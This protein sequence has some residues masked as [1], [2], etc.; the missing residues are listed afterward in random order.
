MKPPPL[1][2]D[3]SAPTGIGVQWL[4][5]DADHEGQR[6]DNYLI[7]RLK[8]APRSLIYRILR[9]GEVR[10]NKGRIKP[11][12]RLHAGDQVRVPPVRL[13]VGT[14]VPKPS[15][16]LQRRLQH[17]VLYEDDDLL[18]VSK[19]SGLAV[20]GGSGIS[21]GLIE[22]LRQ[23]RPDSTLEL[24]HRLDRETSGCLMVAKNRRCLRAVQAQFREGKVNK[25]Y[26]ALAAGRWPNRRREVNTSLLKGRSSSGELIVRAVEPGTN[27]AKLSL[28]KY[29]VLQRYNDSTLLEV[30]PVTGRTHQIR[31]HCQYLGHAIVADAKY[32]NPEINVSFRKFGLKR[33]FLHAAGLQLRDQRGQL[34]EVNAPL[35]DD[36]KLVLDNLASSNAAAQS[37]KI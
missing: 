1:Q 30:K 14:P 13:G 5:I 33:L 28:T 2:K 22:S 27:G 25:S 29:R 15:E 23:M 10:V 17:S 18:I 11:E 3:R 9:K 20:H 19:P 32:G 4:E 8:G 7:N 21:L 35:D 36:L 12:Y 37:L 31:V 6:I 26:W 34:L 16:R 24:I